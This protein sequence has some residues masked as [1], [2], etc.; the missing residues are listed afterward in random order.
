MT[1][2]DPKPKIYTVAQLQQQ[3]EKLSNVI[4]DFSVNAFQSG[5]KEFSAKVDFTSLRNMMIRLR[6]LADTK[7]PQT[8]KS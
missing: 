7:F 2:N 1:T 8:L 6:I 4:N 3:A 5:H